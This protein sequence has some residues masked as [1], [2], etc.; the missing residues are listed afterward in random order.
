MLFRSRDQAGNYRGYYKNG[1]GELE[2]MLSGN[3][4]SKICDLEVAESQ[5]K[6]YDFYGAELF[7]CMSVNEAVTAGGEI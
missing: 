4:L 1:N 2:D 3:S 7:D 5:S 6:D